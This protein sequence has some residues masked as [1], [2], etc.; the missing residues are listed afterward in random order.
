MAREQPAGR[1]MALHDLEDAVRQAGLAIRSF[2]LDRGQRRQLAGLK[3]IA[4]PKAS[5]GADFQQAICSG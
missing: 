4:L 1:G 5:A 3:I 2:E